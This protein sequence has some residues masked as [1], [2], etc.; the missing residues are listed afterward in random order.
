MKA[1]PNLG[2]VDVLTNRTIVGVS[3]VGNKDG[4][5]PANNNLKRK[6]GCQ[7]P[8]GMRGKSD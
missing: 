4:E 8:Y 3:V 5:R 7:D 1:F 6:F 2:R